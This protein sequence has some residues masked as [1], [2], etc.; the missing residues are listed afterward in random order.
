M[1]FFTASIDADTVVG[2]RGRRHSQ[3][4]GEE[5]MLHPDEKRGGRYGITGST[6][7]DG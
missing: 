3:T 6:I 5:R 7:Y 4:C 1:G 2:L